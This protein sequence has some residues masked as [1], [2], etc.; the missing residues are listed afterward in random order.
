MQ[1]IINLLRNYNH[2]AVYAE[3]ISP[4]IAQQVITSMKIIMG[5]DGTNEGMPLSKR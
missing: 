5:E 1:N 2:S 4:P 3:P